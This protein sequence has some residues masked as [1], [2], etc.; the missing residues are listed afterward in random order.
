MMNRGRG[1]TNQL[2]NT[3]IGVHSTMHL[4]CL[5]VCVCLHLCVCVCTCVC[6]Q[7]SENDVYAFDDFQQ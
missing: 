7:A 3:L 2:H 5:F 4:V 6:E 1:Q